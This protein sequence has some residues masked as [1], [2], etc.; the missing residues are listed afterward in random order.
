MKTPP[1]ATSVRTRFEEDTEAALMIPIFEAE[2]VVEPVIIRMIATLR[3][4]I[5]RMSLVSARGLQTADRTKI[6]RAL[7]EVAK[8][9]R[10]YAHL[11]RPFSHQC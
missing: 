10:D 1:T 6:L 9:V 8:E 5:Q 4:W 3:I 2:V 11:I 7:I